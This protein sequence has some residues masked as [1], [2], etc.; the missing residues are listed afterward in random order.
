[1]LVNSQNLMVGLLPTCSVNFYA[2]LAVDRFYCGST[3]DRLML[4]ADGVGRSQDFYK[5]IAMSKFGNYIHDALDDSSHRGEIVVMKVSYEV[6]L[7]TDQDEITDQVVFDL[8]E[9]IANEIAIAVVG[10]DVDSISVEA[11][12]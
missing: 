3:C 2:M 8:E 4:L 6:H 9:D 12:E 11:N 7:T 10:V 1:M 5:G